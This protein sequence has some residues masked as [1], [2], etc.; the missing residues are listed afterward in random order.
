MTIKK[1][2]KNLNIKLKLVD[3]WKD[4]HKPKKGKH[5]I[6]YSPKLKNL[7]TYSQNRYSQ[8]DSLTYIRIPKLSSHTV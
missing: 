2:G 8:I 1:T 5:L 7:K 6:I 4:S 3:F